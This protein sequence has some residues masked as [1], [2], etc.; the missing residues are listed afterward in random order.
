VAADDVSQRSSSSGAQI[1][2]RRMPTACRMCSLEAVPYSP[3]CLPRISFMSPEGGTGG[4]AGSREDT[5]PLQ[6]KLF[7]AKGNDQP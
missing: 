7:E 2:T 1:A 4:H 3:I 5:N 6:M